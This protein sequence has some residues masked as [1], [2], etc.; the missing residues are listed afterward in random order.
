[1]QLE[2]AL[3]NRYR[4]I[5]GRLVTDYIAT[6]G[7]VGSHQIS[8]KLN[9]P[10]S[11][12]TVRNVLK[13]LEEMGYLKQPHT[14]AG[15]VPTD[16]GLRFYVDTL[17]EKNF[18]TQE[19][20][21]K[22][23]TQYKIQDKDIR[24]LM[25]KTSRVLA[26]LSQYV[27]VVVTPKVERTSFKHIEFLPLSQ[28]RLLGI[29]VS[30]TGIVENKILEVNE[31]FNYRELEK[32]NNYCNASF[33]GLTLE[34]ARKKVTKELS[35]VHHEYDKL[36]AKAL[37]LSQELLGDIQ[38]AE[39]VVDGKTR[40]RELLQSLEEKEQLLGVLDSCMQSPGIRIFIGAESHC[41]A[42]KDLSL[43]TS[44]YA[45]G[46]RLLGTL[47]VIGPTSMNYSKVI[48]IVDFTAKMVSNLM[49]NA[50]AI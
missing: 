40:I 14:S 31:E 39:L 19:D 25:Q 4:E 1:M 17:V 27:S 42:T 43:I 48:S 36:L 45:Q 47:G 46:D 15:R 35:K 21:N 22:I 9:T 33:V 49:E 11:S 5:L 12:A 38:P 8:Q 3:N 24:S 6:A 34:E 16:K 23:Q 50:R 37:L 26:D 10:L 29:F 2:N 7:A 18:L 13:D 41:D 32:I 28:G 30:Q 44:T 20:Q